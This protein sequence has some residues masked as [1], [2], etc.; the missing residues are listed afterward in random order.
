GPAPRAP[1][2]QA[3]L[4]RLSPG[5]PARAPCLACLRRPHSCSDSRGE[6]IMWLTLIMAALG[7]VTSII[8]KLIPDPDKA[9]EV[10]AEIRK[11]LIAQ[12]GEV[13]KAIADAA[14]AQTEINLKEAESPS[15]FVAGWRPFI[16]WVCG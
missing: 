3:R 5:G 1:R 13:N 12:E 8:N 10:K 2:A 15:L 4:D 14:R 9:A 16:G 6:I 7:P 11:A